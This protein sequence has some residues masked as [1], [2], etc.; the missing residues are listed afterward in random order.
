[1]AAR[2][3]IWERLKD[4]VV[5]LNDCLEGKASVITWPIAQQKAK[6]VLDLISAPEMGV[7][8]KPKG[9]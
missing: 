4:L 3:N 8:P 2:S 5:S 1:M 7:G 6:K 9:G